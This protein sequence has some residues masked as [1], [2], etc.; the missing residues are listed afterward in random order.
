[1]LSWFAVTK[2]TLRR[3][4]LVDIAIE[5][6]VW[7]CEGEGHFKS[8]EKSW[9]CTPEQ[10]CVCWHGPLPLL[11]RCARSC[12]K[13]WRRTPLP[14]DKP[15]SFAA[16]SSPCRQRKGG[17]YLQRDVALWNI[18]R[19]K[20]WQRFLPYPHILDSWWWK[21]WWWSWWWFLLPSSRSRNLWV[22]MVQQIP[23]QQV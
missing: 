9:I 19:M 21:G 3:V 6:E 7:P 20:W 23:Y 1:M 12:V 16:T 22:A 8:N 5:W 2:G 10:F 13:Q 11:P 15:T 18:L 14:P 4:P 17:S